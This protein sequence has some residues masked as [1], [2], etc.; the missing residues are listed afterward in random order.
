VGPPSVSYWDNNDNDVYNKGAMILHTIR[1]VLNDSILFFDI[2]QTFYSEHAASSH[3]TTADFI[4][5]V[6][7]KTVKDWDKFFEVYLYNRVVPV[8][9]WYSGSYDND[10]E[11]GTNVIKGVPFVVA[12]WTNVPEGFSMPARL[13]CKGGNAS[14]TIEVTTK[15]ILFYLKEMT[16]CNQLV[17]NKRLSYYKAVT[18]KSVLEEIKSLEPENK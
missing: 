16:S 7:R 10:Q 8:L 18:D 9:Y 12:K 15:P 5:V 6:E 4:E 1:N 13:D 17:C 3:V 11:P 14:I 2:L